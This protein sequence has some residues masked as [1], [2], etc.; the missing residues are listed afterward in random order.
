MP[1]SLAIS[2]GESDRCV[3][4]ND[5]SPPVAKDT[6][7]NEIT[8]TN[9]S[10]LVIIFSTFSNPCNYDQQVLVVTEVRDQNGATMFF[11]NAPVNTSAFNSSDVGAL[12]YPEN[13]GTYEL[14]SFAISNS[15]GSQV[16]TGVQTR[17]LVV[18]DY[19]LKSA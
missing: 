19:D 12:W 18:F 3:Q 13:A 15:T 1:N 16:S 7:G 6:D 5:L 17:E 11:Q 14:R 9:A 10:K 8:S 4:S 2:A